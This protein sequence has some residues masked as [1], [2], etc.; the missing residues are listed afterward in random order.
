MKRFYFDVRDGSDNRDADGETFRDDSAARAAALEI[1]S[2]AVRDRG[3][4]LME[5]GS[6][7]V[8]MRDDTGAT[9][10]T[11]VTTATKT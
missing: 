1:A 4:H 11:V 2:A 6:V 5:G 10:F 3:D 9:V 7:R 8:G